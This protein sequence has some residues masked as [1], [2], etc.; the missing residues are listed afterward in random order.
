MKKKLFQRKKNQ[1]DTN[2]VNKEDR[3]NISKNKDNK[4]IYSKSVGKYQAYKQTR[5]EDKIR[6]KKATNQKRLKKDFLVDDYPYMFEP[7]F[8]EHNGLHHA[9]LTFYVR[10]GSNKNLMPEDVLNLIP[11]STYSGVNFTIINDD[12]IIKGDRKK[13]IISKNSSNNRGLIKA[14]DETENEKPDDTKNKKEQRKEVYNDY[15][16][17]EKIIDS[18]VPIVVFKWSLL[19]IGET[20]EDVES[21]IIILNQELDKTRDGA[22]WDSIAGEQQDRLKKLFLPIPESTNELTATGNNYSGLNL[23]MNSGLKD[24]EGMPMGSNF[25]PLY[26]SNVY[27]D[28]EHS[29]QKQAIIAFSRE[30]NL[31]PRYAYSPSENGKEEILDISTSSLIGQYAANQYVMNGHKVQHIIL[32]DF[33]YLRKKGVYFRPPTVSD[34][35]D[36][37]DVMN[38]TI[39][40]MEGFGQL[41]E[42]TIDEKRGSAKRTF[43]RIENRILDIFT[44]LKDFDMT[45]AEKSLILK[46]ITSFY[47]DRDYWK[48]EHTLYPDA[49]AIANLEDPELYATL[50]SF[51]NYFDTIAKRYI[52]ENKKD[53]A[54]NAETLQNTLRSALDTYTD[55][56]ARTTSIQPSEAMQTYYDFSQIRE[57]KLKSIQLVNIID[58]VINNADENDVIVIHGFDQ[59]PEKV[60]KMI[61]ANIKEAQRYGKVRFLFCFD[62]I[63][64]TTGKYGKMNDIFEMNQIFYQD[65]DTDVDWTMIG[66][67]RQDELTRFE[68]A[69]NQYLGE[70]VKQCLQ[71]KQKNLGMIHRNIGS[72]NDFVNLDFFI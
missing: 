10:E 53:L 20:R 35:F 4:G 49:A 65:L 40:P 3:T 33:D 64:S 72:V 55:V 43:A 59:V 44:I 67:L 70:T 41:T 32:N 36:S 66:R 5:K 62:E 25:L 21:Q 42:G 58:Y 24:P 57:E 63:E 68:K 27:F 6:D 12:R 2:S 34:I 19:V 14:T 22:Q 71:Y 39:N 16:E 30:R 17:Y 48:P 47:N 31:V 61:S 60:A 26:K 37:Y 45:E 18:A 15:E 54:Q 11:R 51:L 46:T 8:F 52:D 28:F 1:K 9:I 69:L 29:T 23:A 50:I 13:R 7:S 56:L 38:L